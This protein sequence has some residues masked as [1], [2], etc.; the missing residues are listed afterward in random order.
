MAGLTVFVLLPVFL[1]GLL[2]PIIAG[3]Y[4]AAKLGRRPT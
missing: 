2:G 1:L 3:V 4:L